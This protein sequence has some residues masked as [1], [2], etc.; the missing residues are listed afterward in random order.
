MI[1]EC[2]Q[3]DEFI[4]EKYIENE[5]KYNLE[6]LNYIIRIISYTER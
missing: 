6:D 2:T 1:N 3:M 5:P 4:N